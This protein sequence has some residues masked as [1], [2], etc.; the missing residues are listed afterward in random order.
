MNGEVLAPRAYSEALPLLVS[1]EEAL[2]SSLEIKHKWSNAHTSYR[3]TSFASMF[4]FEHEDI[5]EGSLSIQWSKDKKL[6][7]NWAGL[8][9]FDW[10]NFDTDVPI[11]IETLIDFYG[12]R[13]WK[14]APSDPVD[15]LASYFPNDRFDVLEEDATYAF[16]FPIADFV[17]PVDIRA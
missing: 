15:A 5:Y 2:V 12:F 14:T 6:F 9:N 3:A 4:I 7:C 17:P 8:C 10:R 1:R 13:V 16:I 11:H